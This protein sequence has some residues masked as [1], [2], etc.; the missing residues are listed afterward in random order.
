MSGL[1]HLDSMGSAQMV[2]IDEKDITRRRAIARGSLRATPETLKAILEGK[3]P[4]GD[5]LATARIA[6]IM[7]AKETSRLI[8]LCHPVVLTGININFELDPQNGRISIEACVDALDRTGVEME[9]LTAASVASLTLYDMLKAIDT[10]MVIEGIHVAHKSG[11][12]RDFT[13]DR[14]QASALISSP[15]HFQSL[16]DQGRS[17]RMSSEAEEELKTSASAGLGRNIK[18]IG[19]SQSRSSS[20][21]SEESL[22]DSIVEASASEEE[23][24]LSSCEKPLVQLLTPIEPISAMNQNTSSSM[25]DPS[26]AEGH[27][28]ASVWEESILADVDDEDIELYQSVSEFARQQSLL[29]REVSLSYPPLTAF[30]IERPVE[31]AYLLGYLSPAFTQRSRAFILEGEEDHHTALPKIK[32]LLFIYSG[33]TVP[34]VW[35][36][37]SEQDVEAILF[38]VHDELPRRIYLNIEDHHYHAVRS[39]Y[40]IRGRREILRMGLE[41]SRYSPIGDSS[42]VITL[43]H[44]DTGGIMAL[45]QQYYPDN[46]FEPAQLESG[47]YCGI[48]DEEGRLMSVAGIHLLNPDYRV[49]AIG[50]IVTDPTCRGRG[51]ATQCVRHILDRL[52]ELVDSVALNVNEDNAPAIYCY[53]KFGFK[54]TE[55]LIEGQAKLR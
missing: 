21:P 19:K 51:Y 38:A 27:V 50:N 31:C 12:K 55:R 26:E 22:S 10:K 40:R 18:V 41:R 42:G 7:A 24:V 43:G 33:L 6:G 46:L 30:I 17:P 48:K 47:L 1:T 39:H 25:E 3:T 13:V 36:Y 8:P 52:F 34:T 29:V 23:L 11:G 32:A 15:N 16:S 14:S 49:A 2:A 45:F 9:A 54:T 35:T 37:G 4:K 5:V 28:D 44:P 53:R 20:I